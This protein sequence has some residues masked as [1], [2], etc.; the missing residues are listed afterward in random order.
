MT[1]NIAGSVSA[2]H[3]VLL[4]FFQE[5]LTQELLV[6]ERIR[7]VNEELFVD[8]ETGAL[9]FSL[10]SVYKLLFDEQKISFFE[11]KR[12]LYQGDFNTSLKALGGE[13]SVYQSEGKIDDNLYQLNV[14]VNK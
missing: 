4:T 3:Q 8:A 5:F 1:N 2:T 9:V 6:I 12:T 14:M 11:F 13:V 7:H 10:D